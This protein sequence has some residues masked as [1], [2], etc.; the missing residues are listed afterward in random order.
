MTTYTTHTSRPRA[1]RLWRARSL[2]AAMLA[3]VMGATAGTSVAQ[4]CT[5]ERLNLNPQGGVAYASSGTADMTPDGRFVALG[6]DAYSLVAGDTNGFQDA[7]VRDRQLGVT[8]LVSLSSTGAQ[9]SGSSNPVRISADGR[10]VLFMSWADDVHPDDPDT[11]LDFFVRDRTLGTT[12]LISRR[13]AGSP[14][15]CEF[16]ADM[17][18]DGR[19]VV[20]YSADKLI[21]PGDTDDSL[22]VFLHDRNSTTTILVS[23]DGQGIKPGIPGAGFPSVSDDG[24]RVTFLAPAPNWIPGNSLTE[25]IW[26]K[27][28]NDDSVQLITVRPDGQPSFL[29]SLTSS[30]SGNGRFVAFMNRGDD[31]T[32]DEIYNGWIEDIYVRDVEAGA[33]ELITK[34]WTGGPANHYSTYP[35]ITADGR[36]VAF[37]SYA[38]NLVAL[39][40]NG[41]GIPDV[42]VHDRQT[43]VT[44]LASVG[45]Q[46]QFSSQGAYGA[47]VSDDG[48]VVTFTSLDPG[49]LPG[50][51]VYNYDAYLRECQP[52]VTAV[53]CVAQTNSLGCI[54]LVTSQGTASVTQG[55]GFDVS[56]ERLVSGSLGIFYYGTS[57]TASGTL[58]GFSQC[59]KPPTIR[60]PV[61]QTG[62]SFPPSDCTGS[63]TI[64]FNAWIAAG[65]DP[66]LVAGTLVYGQFWSRDPT[67]TSTIHL[68][69]AV[70]FAIGP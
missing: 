4:Q 27:D 18:S 39:D 50:S 19:F 26:L 15:G 11:L 5:I 48:R 36:F 64:D 70:A 7:F 51:G 34:S 16:E 38:S 65:S 12:E 68:S 23:V 59:V 41:S 22:D 52:D 6:S 31:L 13:P 30:I 62:G 47:R 33:T 32:P 20:F 29:P 17:S 44:T 24:K 46:G 54:P 69:P 8:E 45:H 35:S 1:V 43:S 56:C 55:G 14:I 42:F 9:L 57:G 40:G 63:L 58:L 53:Y 61:A 25:Q 49:L 2:R 10:Y 66:S 3:T 28:L 60:T 21:V 67:A 37:V